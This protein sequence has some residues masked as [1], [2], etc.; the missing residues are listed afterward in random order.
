[1]N[2]ECQGDKINFV[3]TDSE[4]DS[5]REDPWLSTVFASRRGCV[6]YMTENVPDEVRE[7][8]LKTAVDMKVELVTINR[9]DDTDLLSDALNR[10][11]IEGDVRL[12]L[13]F[14]PKD[15]E[16]AFGW[17]TFK[18]AIDNEDINQRNNLSGK[19]TIDGRKVYIKD[20]C[21]W[22]G[23]N[24]L[25][26]F[27]STFGLGTQDKTLM[28]NYKSEMT[29]GLLQMPEDYVRYSV[30]DGTTL[31][32]VHAKFLE[33]FQQIQLEVLGMNVEDL[34]DAENIPMTVGS[35]VAHTF[36][37][38]LYKQFPEDGILKFCIR[39]L[40]TLDP[41]QKDYPKY[42][43]AYHSVVYRYR[44][45]EDLREDFYE[46]GIPPD[47]GRFYKAEFVHNAVNAASVQ[48][49][50]SL[51]LIDSAGFSALVQG[52]R[53]HNE[54]PYSYSMGHGGDID[55]SGCYGESLR[56]FA[57]PV[58][59]PS[60]WSVAP[61]QTRM[62]L[63][64]WLD[65]YNC[66]LLDGLWTVTVSGK[67]DFDQDLIHSKLVKRRDIRKAVMND[68]E[69]DSDIPSNFILLRR[70]IQHGIITSDVLRALQAVSTNAEWKTFRNLEID[71]A[72]A[73][74]KN[75][76]CQGLEDWCDAVLA[77]KG[78]YRMENGVAK[79]DRTRAW[80]CLPLENFIGKL[81][82]RRKHYKNLMRDAKTPDEMATAKG[83][84]EML[85]LIINTFYGVEASRY[86]DIGNTVVANSITARAR[87]GVW[88]VAKALG[89]RQCITDGGMYDPKQVCF[90]G[91]K[92][93]GIDI[94]S[95]P[96]DFKNPACRRWV[97]PLEGWDLERNPTYTKHQ[98]DR[99][100]M[101][102]VAQDHVRKFWNP[103]GLVFPFGLE[104]K[105]FFERAVYWGKGDYGLWLPKDFPFEEGKTNPVYKL[106]GKKDYRKQGGN[107]H[108]SYVLFDNVLAG[109]D[110]FPQDMEH[111]HK[112]LMKIGKYRIVQSSNGYEE[113]K[114]LR[115]GDEYVQH[116]KAR[117][118]N[119][120]FPLKNVDDYENRANRK[121]TVNG[122]DVLWFER[123]G[124]CGIRFVHEAM[125]ENDMRKT[126]QNRVA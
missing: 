26:T 109:S 112:S 100:I 10:L 14:S 29:K 125:C 105:C 74:L 25:K 12:L 94:L 93:P 6:L 48:Y 89:L 27:L 72:A 9:T 104:H 34:W 55:I 114:D 73:Y 91:A 69:D 42:L 92:K 28:D 17:K 44:K 7:R 15:L 123:Y 119:S 31:L 59:L 37:K 67:L 75:D 70:E 87:V 111:T 51:P 116:R 121:K 23:K 124:Q 41:D 120:Y 19:I 8:S 110:D 20:L 45:A 84:S 118:N 76:Q 16:L 85:K 46:N 62:K 3:A 65:K 122:N 38:W 101:D 39:K 96:W 60:V 79:D 32:E 106:R 54:Q 40:G 11:G 58:G 81:A 52:G 107:C 86:F 50:A 103:Y 33:A 30:G 61:N 64:Q 66:E 77:D 80:T 115:P 24:S 47:L 63:G 117:Y 99:K 22:A 49:W 113:L 78:S 57:Y 53:C 83:M 18:M 90:F 2:I 36:E 97:L 88:M 126:V 82:D 102:S 98:D 4:W 68:D 5:N 1:M 108:P 21:G 71:C 43:S 56:S 35:L 95:R 13:F